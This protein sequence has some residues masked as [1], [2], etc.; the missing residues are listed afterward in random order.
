MKTAFH[1]VLRARIINLKE[2]SENE[3]EIT[4]REEKFEKEEPI[5]ARIEA[6]SRYQSYIDIL[7]ES[8]GIKCT[9]AQDV[10]EKLKSFY[11]PEI[12]QQNGSEVQPIDLKNN[13]DFGIGVF[14]SIDKPIKGLVINNK[15]LFIHGVGW[16]NVSPE[17]HINMLSDE[18][19][20]FEHYNYK[21]KNCKQVIPFISEKGFLDTT[22]ESLG[23]K[24]FT[25]LATPFDWKKYGELYWWDNLEMGNIKEQMVKDFLDIINSG[26]TSRVEFNS[27]LLFSS[28]TNNTSSKPRLKIAKS[29]CALMNTNGGILFIGVNENGKIKGLDNDFKLAN[30]M[31]THKYFRK[32]LDQILEKYIS[33]P[34]NNYLDTGFCKISEKEI[35]FI[36]VKASE[37]RPIFFIGNA[38]KKFYVRGEASSRRLTDIEE[39][40]NYCIDRFT[41]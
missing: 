14:M 39:I 31:N 10:R 19:K 17:D 2:G 22:D 36:N 18:H 6:I 7:F 28:K 12:V 38:G 32:E 4:E 5:N 34:I 41:V 11:D 29:I 27:A 9:N 15:C 37:R 26:E 3:Y 16:G 25:I 33:Y 35:F 21:T 1:Y 8:K 40:A 13:T 30:E 24:N 23:L 20:Y